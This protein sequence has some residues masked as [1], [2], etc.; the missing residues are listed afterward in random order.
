MA[1]LVLGAAGAALGGS[2]LPAGFSLLGAS[3]TGAAIGRAVGALAGGYIDSALFGASGQSRV[4]DGPRLSDLSVMASSEGAHIPRLYG[5]ARLAGQMIW[6]THLEEVVSKISSGGA[7]GLSQPTETGKS[8]EYFA[9]F[10]IGLCEG[11][12][13]HVGRVWADGT[14]LDLSRFTYR[15]HTGS[16]DQAPDSLIEAKEGTGS[17][18]AYRGLAYIVFER[19]PLADFGNRIPQLNFEVFRPVDELEAMVRAVTLI[20]AAGEFAYEPTLEV[21][22]YEGL[23]DWSPENTNTRLGRTDCAASIDQ[24]QS[25]LHSAGNV[26][27]FAAWFGDDLRCASCRI[28]PMVDRSN[29]LTAPISWQVQG[30]AR[31]DAA[32]VSS[33]ESKPSYGGTPSDSTVR[34]LIVDLQARGLSPTLT[35]FLLMDIPSGNM[36]PDPWTGA[37]GQDAYPWRGR[38]SV[39]PAPGQ[40]GSADQT[41]AAQAQ[42]AAFLGTAT[43]EDF[44]VIK[45]GEVVYSGPDEWSYRRFILHYAFLAKAAQAISGKALDAFII[46]SEMR[47]LTWPRGAAGQFPFVDGLVALAADVKSVLPDT[48]LSY[49][50]D[51]SEL[52]PYQTSQFGGPAGEVFFHLDKLWASPDIDAVGIDNYWP[53]ADWRDGAEHADYLAGYRSIYDPA[54]LKANIEGGEGYDWFYQDDAARDSQTRTPITDGLGKPWVFRYKDIRNWWMNAHFDRPGGVESASPTPWAAQSKPIWFLEIGCPAVDKGA[55]QPNVFS[56]PKSAESRLPHYSSGRRDDLMQRRYIRSMIEWYDPTHPDYA[57]GNPASTV[58]GGRMVDPQRIYVYTWDARPFPAFPNR[59]DVWADGV[60]WQLGHW[61]TGRAAQAPVPETIR[62]ILLDYGFE[63]ASVDGLS[64]A[65]SGYVIDAISSARNALQPLETAF[66]FDSVERGGKIAFRPRAAPARA[67]S[68][69]LDDLAETSSGTPR[70]S[71]VRAQESEL[72]GRAKLS[73]IN[74]EADYQRAMAE[75]LRLAGKSERVASASFAIATRQAEM[76]AVAERLLHE[77][78][79]A[80]ERLEFALPP[81]LF[82]A[83]PG[84]VIEIDTGKRRLDARITRLGIGPALSI[85]ALSHDPGIYEDVLTP[86]RQ[87]APASSISFGAPEFAFLDLPVLS[88]LD[89]PHAGRAAAFSNPFGGVNVLRSPEPTG[90]ILNS[91]LLAPATMGRTISPLH[92]G[93]TV[94]MDRGNVLRAQFFA[95]QTELSSVTDL[96]L[97]GGANLLGVEAGNGEWELLQFQTA[98]LVSPGIY[99]LSGLLRGRFGTEDAMRDMLG[100]QA[101]IVL[102]DGAVAQLAMDQD[103]IGLEFHWRYGPVPRPVDHFTYLTDVFAFKGRGLKPYAPV[104]LRAK[105]SLAGDLILSWV[106]RDRLNADSWEPPEIPMSEAGESYEVDILQAGEVVRTISTQAPEATY[107]AALQIDDFGALQPGLDVRVY[108]MSAVVG[109]GV[110]AAAFV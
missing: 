96:A 15:V 106:R 39:D 108:Q 4:L 12:I 88:G 110:A 59:A 92:A 74:A 11:P 38:I 34:D 62:S 63:N 101:R 71:V 95:P 2:L 37:P 98:E 104:H 5:R 19:M 29:K 53:L 100:T 47:A 33:F 93:P 42:I 89:V 103:D 68:A 75:S 85:E 18:P 28:R 52:T 99:D 21:Q 3:V 17:A 16:Q 25:V 23:G 105:R 57:G 83:E 54:Y 14:E 87:D 26:A 10:A 6:A 80:R 82:A 46:G 67:G 97:L 51:W 43:P 102:I 73:F 90:F 60:N 24:L 91:Q 66:F 58:Y 72:P 7:K 45:G 36:L 79:A 40:A 48:R 8:Y 86:E 13:S 77:Q 49:A 78:W 76:Q 20:P 1:T 94:V 50:A 84:D 107:G 69:K 35:P 27:V 44:A 31:A 32:V 41:S 56:D 9:N 81:S 61:L 70:L 55:N 30:I 64:G 109:R 65:M 22:R